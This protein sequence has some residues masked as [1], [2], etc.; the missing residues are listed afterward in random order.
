[1][2]EHEKSPVLKIVLI[3][4]GALVAVGI[5]VGVVIGIGVVN[6]ISK[7][8]SY[9]TAVNETNSLALK[10]NEMTGLESVTLAQSTDE[11]ALKEAAAR[12][13]EKIQE[14]IDFVEK[15]VDELGNEDGIT[16]DDNKA[17]ELYEILK[18]KKEA[19]M[20]F[21]KIAIAAYKLKAKGDFTGAAEKMLTGDVRADSEFVAALN[22]LNQYLVKKAN[23]Q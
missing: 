3:I 11:K 4:I 17:K 22:N 21:Y 10:Y 13:V 5:V 2:T 12:D 18:N 6:E 1:M 14:I 20:D 15:K 9:K 8:D 19:F 23:N 16:V 7:L